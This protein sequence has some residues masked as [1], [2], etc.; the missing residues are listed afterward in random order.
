MNLLKK[1]F[2]YFI[3]IVLPPFYYA[4]VKRVKIGSKC[5]ISTKYW[6][7]E[8][9]LIDIGDHVHITRGVRF[10]NHDGGVWVFRNENPRFDVFGKIKIGYNTF[11][12]NDAT[13]LYGVCIGSN[14]IIGAGSIV[15]KSVPDGC[16]VAGNPAKYICRTEDYYKKIEPYNTSLKLSKNKRKELLKIDEKYFIKRKSIDI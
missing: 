9:F 14:C 6:G 3:Y 2:N 5:Q 16:V 12:G 10:V 7:S 8:P 15:T 13:I 1:I 11:I 4:K